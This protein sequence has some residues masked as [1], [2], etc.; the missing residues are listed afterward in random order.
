MEATNVVGP[1]TVRST[2]GPVRL[3]GNQVHAP[4][5]IDGNRTGDAAAV[6]D[7]NDITGP[8]SCRNN[9][10]PP[11]DDDRPNRVDG[12]VSGQCRDM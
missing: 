10:P 7:D 4:V 8:L 5:T 11:T 12:P 6:I 2:T 1:L 3:D 9:T